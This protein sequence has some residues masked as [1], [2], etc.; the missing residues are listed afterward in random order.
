MPFVCFEQSDLT[1]RMG[2]QLI[3]SMLGSRRSCS[4]GLY[5]TRDTSGLTAQC[6]RDKRP[7]Q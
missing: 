4:S 6:N 7:W 1:H 2:R 3:H 5:R